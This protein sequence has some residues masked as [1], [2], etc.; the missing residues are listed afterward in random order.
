M[1]TTLTLDDD[2]AAALKEVAYRS[3]RSFKDVVNEALRA[4]LQ[5]QR[6]PARAKPYR[7][8]VVS[9]GAVAPSVN[10]DKALRL[11]DEL[12]AEG[13]THKLEARK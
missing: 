3:E 2:L 1:R 13:I 9:M 5:A 4:G 11:A 6:Q 10:L 8:S 12:E 7:L